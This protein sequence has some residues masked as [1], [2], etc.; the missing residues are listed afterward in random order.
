MSYECP[1][2][3]QGA[4]EVARAARREAYSGRGGQAILHEQP[5]ASAAARGWLTRRQAEGAGA[6]RV[7]LVERRERGGTRDQGDSP[8]GT[9]PG[10][11]VASFPADGV[12]VWTVEEPRA[13][14]API[15]SGHDRPKLAGCWRRGRPRRTLETRA[16]AASPR[17][18]KHARTN[19]SR[20]V[21]RSALAKFGNGRGRRTN[22]SSPDVQR[23]V[24]IRDATRWV[25]VRAREYR[26]PLVR[27]TIRKEPS[28]ADLSV[29][30]SD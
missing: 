6:D 17:R 7:G 26:P 3:G 9:L 14:R 4:P 20:A 8:A 2:E 5:S 19:A 10:R 29:T 16:Q 24:A 30:R 21:L 28:P 23:G 18:T 11:G 12:L 27:I 1:F 13:T 22:E 25:R 15:R